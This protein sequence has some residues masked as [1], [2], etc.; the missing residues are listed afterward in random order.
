MVGGYRRLL[1]QCGRSAV[2]AAFW[3][4]G[5]R[6]AVASPRAVATTVRGVVAVV[7]AALVGL[8]L[9]GAAATPAG[10]QAQTAAELPAFEEFGQFLVDPARPDVIILNGPIGE[11]ALLDFRRAERAFPDARTLVLNSPG[12]LVATGLTIADEL[13]EDGFGTVIPSWAGCYSAC[14]FLFLAGVERAAIGELG[15]HQFYSDDGTANTAQLTV[16][17]ILDVLT[18]FGTSSDLISLMLRTPPDEIHVLDAREVARFG[19]N[20]GFAAGTAD[21][22]FAAVAALSPMRG[23]PARA[24]ASLFVNPDDWREIDGEVEWRVEENDG[25]VIVAA[26]VHIGDDELTVGLAL[27]EIF[28][29]DED[30]ALALGVALDNADYEFTPRGGT[31]RTLPRGSDDVRVTSFGLAALPDPGDP[32]ILLS[33]RRWALADLGSLHDADVIEIWLTDRSGESAVLRIQTTSILA[34]VLDEWATQAAELPIGDLPDEEEAQLA[35]VTVGDAAEP[36]EGTATW[37]MRGPQLG[38]RAFPADRAYWV[39]FGFDRDRVYVAFEPP[40][41]F[42]DAAVVGLAPFDGLEWDRIEP[43]YYTAELSPQA[44]SRLAVTL[45]RADSFELELVLADDVHMRVVVET[46]D[47]F[48]TMLDAVL[49]FWASEPPEERQVAAAPTT[50]APANARRPDYT[51]D[52]NYGELTLSGG[53]RPDP[54]TV[55]LQAGGPI[56]AAALGDTCAGFI[57]DAPDLRIYLTAA[58]ADLFLSVVSASDTTLIVND[59]TGDWLCADDNGNSPNPQLQLERPVDGQYDIWVGN[60]GSR[61]LVD[62]TLQI[63]T[64]T[65]VVSNGT[66]KPMPGNAGNAANDGGPFVDLGVYRDWAVTRNDETC[67]AY[68]VPLSVNPRN[69]AIDDTFFAIYIA[70]GEREGFPSFIFAFD[71]NAD[72]FVTVRIDGGATFDFDPED[73]F[74]YLNRSY[75]PTVVLRAL[76]NGNAMEAVSVTATGSTRTERYSLLGATAALAAAVAACR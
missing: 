29:R 2:G 50:T 67:I 31:V 57:S 62:A 15:L 76:Q 58:S 47:A 19:V 52:P 41:A 23:D 12:G 40:S 14:A 20:V 6:G 17:D 56:D 3:A 22:E 71:P 11:S 44:I 43:G 60:R 16:A 66:T 26:V 24:A 25:E 55:R 5:R 46:G 21:F 32:Y 64:H 63:G 27:S 68:T 34:S 49:D 39:D 45:A 53:F 74:A 61:D 75:D 37:Y 38:V 36:E 65:G 1:G 35:L 69:S 28:D 7:S 13:H 4:L 51:L 59:P 72:Y 48:D 42:A 54:Q 70:R 8:S 9:V 33:L 30:A 18:R 10:A 73:N